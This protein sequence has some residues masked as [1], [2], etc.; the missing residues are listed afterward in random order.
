M[1]YPKT[2]N[3]PV[4]RSTKVTTLLMEILQ[5]NTYTRFQFLIWTYTYPNKRNGSQWFNE[6]VHQ[7]G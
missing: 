4:S 2:V 6:R 5:R 3:T 7:N 1:V